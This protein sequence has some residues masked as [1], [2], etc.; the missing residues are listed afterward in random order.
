MGLLAI[1]LASLLVSRRQVERSGDSEDPEMARREVEPSVEDSYDNE[2]RSRDLG[3]NDVTADDD[4][5]AQASDQQDA[6]EGERDESSPTARRVTFGTT[7]SGESSTTLERNAAKPGLVT[8]LKAII[9]PPHD[10]NER[11]SN[12]RVLPV[13]SGLVIPFSILLEI[14]GLTD[15][16]YIR[17]DQNVI[18]ESRPN[19]ISV[20]VLLAI[21]MFFAVVANVSLI[22]RFLEKGPVLTTTLTTIASLTLHDMVNIIVLI[23]F[24]VQHR[25]NGGFTYGHAYWMTVCSTS[26][27]SATNISLVW[28]L[29]WTRHFTER[30]SGVSRK[31]RSLLIIV[32]LLLVYVAF[33]ALV[34]SFLIRLDFIDALYFTVV[35]IETVGFGDIV[36]INTASRVFICF[37]IIFGIL[38][39][40]VAVGVARETIFEWLQIS[41]QRRLSKIRR[42]HEERRRW[43]VWERKW[44]RA[45]EWR[46][47]EMGAD[48]WTTDFTEDSESGSM[49]GIAKDESK[50]ARILL[51]NRI[52]HTRFKYYE[53]HKYFR[54]E[55]QIRG[56]S[57]GYPGTHLNVEALSRAQL[58]AVAVESGVPQ[59]ILRAARSRRSYMTRVHTI[60]SES[61]ASIRQRWSRWFWSERESPPTER[62]ATQFMR[63]LEDM[64][65]MLTKFAIATTG[66]GM[67]RMPLWANNFTQ[68][69]YRQRCQTFDSTASDSTTVSSAARSTINDDLQEISS[70]EERKAFWAKLIV[71]L[72]MF[73]IFW[74]VGAALFVVTEKWTFGIAVYFCF[75][76]FTTTGYGDYTPET[77]A[78]R[79]IFV[80]WALLGLATMTI[81]V[82][83][84]QD[85]FSSKYKSALHSGVF[86]NAVKKYRQKTKKENE[87]DQKQ[88]NIPARIR[89]SVVEESSA[90][91]QRILEALPG[92][93]LE[94]T[95][96]FHRYIQYL[97]QAHSGEVVTMDLMLMLD[98]I[99]RAQKLDDRMKEEILQDDEAKNMLCILNFERALRELVDVAE[100]TRSALFERDIIVARYKEQQQGSGH[101]NLEGHASGSGTYQTHSPRGSD[102]S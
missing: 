66:V 32:I 12:H 74:L 56:I 95:R 98:D 67:N 78:G 42:T 54:E 37:Y 30:G 44:K 9:F 69:I 55:G 65:G 35:S 22:C 11:L 29:L 50:W 7:P 14:P 19:P 97:L 102:V 3:P 64:S 28:D 5:S 91:A 41:Y 52:F 72:T 92:K 80:F 88:L 39:L 2:R 48:T 20:D 100:G 21:S 71:T 45:V 15:S 81:L 17:T 18:V 76:T 83:V 46:L 93:V 34:N 23:L 31:Q 63:G 90:R 1:F 24:S 43:R 62:P 79:S 60:G 8:R 33:G 61:S 84:L 59:H 70:L 77:P 38:N 99:S 87:D 96:V 68:D 36:P 40:G 6:D 101:E 75:I 4:E 27:S 58:E 25:F 85:A 26:V 51:V 13:I 49:M 73:M 53:H 10:E 57:Y 47:K 82:S 94:Q 86:E 89:P 16:W